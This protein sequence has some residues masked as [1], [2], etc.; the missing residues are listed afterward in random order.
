MT[1]CDNEIVYLAVTGNVV[2]TE[3]VDHL[4]IDG[5]TLD[6]PGMGTFEVSGDKDHC[7][8]GLLRFR[9]PS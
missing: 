2:L 5:K 9:A 8:A 6:A 1:G 7:V 4:I 3:R